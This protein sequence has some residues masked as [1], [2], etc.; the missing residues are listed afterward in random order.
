MDNDP[1]RR[2]AV[3]ALSSSAIAA[4]YKGNKLEGIKIVRQ[5]RKI[6]LKEAKDV[7]EEYLASQPSLESNI[8][9]AQSEGKRGVLLWLIAI[10]VLVI[11]VY[12]WLMAP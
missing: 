4:L 10:V 7:V 9:A 3:P 2:I 1:V 8:A 5:E 12:R 11:V 6:G